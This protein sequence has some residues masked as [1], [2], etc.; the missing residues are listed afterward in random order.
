MSDSRL[1]PARAESAAPGPGNEPPKQP[2]NQAVLGPFTVRDLAVFAGVL[3]TFIGSL[4]PMM[5]LNTP[6]GYPNLWNAAG[7][8]YL[9]I[10]V[11]VPLALAGLFV[12]RR[13]A[14]AASIRI[15]SLSLDQF[16][17]VVA[18]LSA[19]FFFLLAVTTASL[20]GIIG[21]LGG[22]ILV[23]ATVFARFI[24][25]LAGDFEGRAEV[26]A[27]V[28]AR[29]AVAPVPKPKPQPAA[30]SQAQPGHPQ[31]S[32]AQPVSPQTS[33]AGAPW[34]GSFEHDDAG[35]REGGDGT[36]AFGAGVSAAGAAAAAA[37][38]A[39]ATAAGAGVA[40]IAA[41]ALAAGEGGTRPEEAEQAEH[42]DAVGTPFEADE[43]PAEE[44][45]ALVPGFEPEPDVTS[46][47]EPEMTSAAE[48]D[49][50]AALAEPDVTSAAE[51]ATAVVIPGDADGEAYGAPGP[52]SPAGA[53]FG[54]TR[55]MPAAAA[56]AP[57]SREPEASAAVDR[58]AGLEATQRDE[59][60][61]PAYDAFWFAVSESRTAVDPQSGLPVFTLDPGQ[62]IL[63]L[64]DRGSEF[65]VQS[66]D[67]RVGVL[68]D[69]SG[70]ERG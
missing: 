25:A 6:Y 48:S 18:V 51:P 27:H 14:P 17:S 46:T 4:L 11:L 15:G 59:E 8:Y 40:A 69:L 47:A 37:G 3:V 26:P 10:G 30:A 32:A 9:G 42:T 57:E 39:G 56:T 35:A 70:I 50:R 61:E 52:E 68:R 16:A 19:T 54:H 33:A 66:Q 41:G 20:G 29:D 38:F 58:S 63:A 7:L 34:A 5:I 23:A 22:A 28:V 21:F 55:L 60:P 2:V 36:P 45:Q 62:W 24:P 31:P 44:P 67:G 49:A 12:W 13:L 64:Q 53:D 65:L 43:T 1:G